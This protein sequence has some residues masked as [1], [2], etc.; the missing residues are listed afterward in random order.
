MPMIRNLTEY[1]L[2]EFFYQ[3]A[4]TTFVKMLKL[5]LGVNCYCQ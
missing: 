3:L 1:L 4:V 5:L 2:G